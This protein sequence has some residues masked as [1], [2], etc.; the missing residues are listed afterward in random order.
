MVANPDRGQRDRENVFFFHLRS[1]PGFCSRE[2]GAAAVSSRVRPI[3]SRLR[4]DLVL[5]RGV[6]PAFR[7]GVHL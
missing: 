7:D 6:H 1:R 3:C 2:T 5:I 4:L